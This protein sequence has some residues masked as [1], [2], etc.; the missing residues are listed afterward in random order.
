MG[1]R[2][3]RW[4][5]PLESLPEGLQRG[6]SICISKS[7]GKGD[8]TLR[9]RVIPEEEEGNWNGQM[10]S[11]TWTQVN[12]GRNDILISSSFSLITTIAF[13]ERLGTFWGMGGT[14]AVPHGTGRDGRKGDVGWRRY[15]EQRIR[16]GLGTHTKSSKNS[17]GSNQMEGRERC[18]GG[19]CWLPGYVLFHRSKAHCFRGQ[20]SYAWR[21]A[22]RCDFIGAFLALALCACSW[23]LNDKISPPPSFIPHSNPILTSETSSSSIS[24][25]VPS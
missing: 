7:P 9:T 5:D 25:H 11:K 21:H 16:N 22:T 13:G 8:H 20:R 2:Q 18:A 19:W 6:W 24:P 1:L 23:V 3:L 10:M 17:V 12:G 4:L 14:W 15:Q